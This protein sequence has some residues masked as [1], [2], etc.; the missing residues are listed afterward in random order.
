ELG[1]FDQTVSEV[2]RPFTLTAGERLAVSLRMTDSS[3]RIFFVI[4]GLREEL[5]AANPVDT[6]GFRLDVRVGDD[7][8]ATLAAATPLA[9]GAHGAGFLVD[10]IDRDVFTRA[11]T[12]GE[13]LEINL[14]SDG[15][16]GQT[17]S[18]VTRLLT[19]LPDAGV[20]FSIVSQDA[21]A[22]Q[23]TLDI[24]AGG[25]LGF[26]VSAP[27]LPQ[28]NDAYVLEI[29]AS[30]GIALGDP[31]R[32]Q[33]QILTG[34]FGDDTLTG[35]SGTDVLDGRGGADMLF[36]G[37]GEDT[38]SYRFSPGPVTV[39]LDTGEGARNDA[40]GDML[41]DIESLIGSDFDDVL[42][43]DFDAGRLIG[44]AGDDRLIGRGPLDFVYG[45][46]GD[47]DIT[48][49]LSNS[50]FFGGEG[51]DTFSLIETR[52]GVNFLFGGPG[53]DTVNGGP[54]I[55]EVE[56]NAGDD[57]L[58]G[59]NGDDRLFGGAGADVLQGRSG[60]D[61]LIGGGG[62]D[63]LNPG[64]G[65]DL[66]TG[67]AGPDLFVFTQA[68]NG[69]NRIT[70]FERG[71]DQVDLTAYGEISGLGDLLIRDVGGAARI[72]SAAFGGVIDLDGIAAADV[73]QS[74]FLFSG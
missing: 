54:S 1:L 51:N 16:P 5:E 63:V 27:N 32:V 68:S 62:A 42:I 52:R 61:M 69:I 31:E 74:D 2:E 71:R 9:P 20:E 67:G 30:L 47:D 10:E 44:R 23:A 53:D 73:S 22:G 43:D 40:Q 59:N 41:D 49:N 18:D 60:G 36:G 7:H 28:P 15:P 55:D 65:N 19:F 39:R 25:T 48:G 11:V 70:D 4:N 29:A 35:G 24:L 17:P 21:A 33:F 46:S 6:G 66:L 38:A 45:R 14:G 72:S 12:A 26:E 13:R 57:L 64:T 56:G 37:P 58:V 50:S 8:G 3:G 34:F